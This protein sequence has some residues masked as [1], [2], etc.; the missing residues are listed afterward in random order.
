VLPIKIDKAGPVRGIYTRLQLNRIFSDYIYAYLHTAKSALNV[1][2]TLMFILSERDDETSAPIAVPFNIA[3]Y[4]L[5]P[6]EGFV[7]LVLE[8]YPPN[9]YQLEMVLY[10]RFAPDYKEVEEHKIMF[11]ARDI[12]GSTA[13]TVYRCPN[14]EGKLMTHHEMASENFDR[15]F[16]L[17]KGVRDDYL[18]AAVNNYFTLV[19]FKRLKS[20]A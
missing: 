4:E 15:W 14:K 7:S 18:A 20:H 8:Q 13:H 9:I 11:G 10:A 17:G 1:V 3:N 2:P 5:E 16:P 12:G 6:L 19:S